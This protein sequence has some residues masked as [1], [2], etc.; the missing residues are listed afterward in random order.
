MNFLDFVVDTYKERFSQGG[1]TKTKD[2]HELEQNM[3]GIVSEMRRPG[4]IAHQQSSYLPQHP[5]HNT[6]CQ[7]T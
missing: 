1:E 2:N 7:V 5:K 6:H 4:R 3:S